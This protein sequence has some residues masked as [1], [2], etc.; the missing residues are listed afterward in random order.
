MIVGLLLAS[1]AGCGQAEYQVT[2]QETQA[3]PSQETPPV[4]VAPTEEPPMEPAQQPI[5]E[6]ETGAAAPALPPEPSEPEL[7]EE[8]QPDE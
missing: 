3:Q 8:N 2:A 6:P 5:A 7:E 1:L 4:S